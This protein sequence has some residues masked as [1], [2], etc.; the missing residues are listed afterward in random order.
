MSAYQV[1]KQ[2]EVFT[3]LQPYNPVLVGTVPIGIDID[4]SDLDI[5]CE[6]ADLLQFQQVVV[7]GFSKYAGFSDFFSKDA[8]VASFRYSGIEIEIYSKDKPTDLQNGYRHMVIEDRILN[9]AGEKL[10]QEVILLKKEGYKTEPAFGQL[11]G[12]AN[13]YEELLELEDLSDAE[14]ED[15]LRSRYFS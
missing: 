3:I 4:G 6:A 5:I 13:P 1:L 9:I 7:D 14:L 11:L 10:R 15:Y 8:Y 2:I 12:L